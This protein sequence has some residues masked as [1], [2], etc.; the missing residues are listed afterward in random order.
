MKQNRMVRETKQR[1]GEEGRTMCCAV[2]CVVPETAPASFSSHFTAAKTWNTMSCDE[3]EGKEESRK[4][5]ESTTGGTEG[6]EVELEACIRQ[7]E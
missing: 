7:L 3:G 2:L 6:G 4:K 5:G 1:E